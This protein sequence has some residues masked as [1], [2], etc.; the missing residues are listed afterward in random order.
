[1]S[2]RFRVYDTSILRAVIDAIDTG[3]FSAGQSFSYGG[4]YGSTV[5]STSKTLTRNLGADP[6]SF[7][8]YSNWSAFETAYNTARYYI[9]AFDLNQTNHSYNGVTTLSAGLEQTAITPLRPLSMLTI[10]W[11]I[12]IKVKSPFITILRIMPATPFLR[13]ATPLR[14]FPMKPTTASILRVTPPR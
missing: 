13:A 5:S 12:R 9:A 4:T 2:V 10:T 1:M 11:V 14:L 7:K 6:Q 8:F 3:N